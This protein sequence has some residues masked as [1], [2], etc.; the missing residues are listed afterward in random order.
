MD[1]SGRQVI[2]GAAAVVFGRRHLRRHLLLNHPLT[3]DRVR[4]VLLL[5]ERRAAA[6]ERQAEARSTA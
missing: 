2:D 3:A 6:A 4:W 1:R 5:A